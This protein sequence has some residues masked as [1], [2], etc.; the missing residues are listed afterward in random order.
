MFLF[1]ILRLS[2]SFIDIDIFWKIKKCW[3][4]KVINIESS[5]RGGNKKAMLKVNE[6]KIKKEYS[7]KVI[8]QKNRALK[9]SEKNIF[10]VFLKAYCYKRRKLICKI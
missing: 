10:F 1:G 8:R 7:I 5:K 9:K 3:L 6:N 4:I 2:K